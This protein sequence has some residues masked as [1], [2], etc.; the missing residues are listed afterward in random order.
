MKICCRCFQKDG[1][2]VKAV[3]EVIF[4]TIPERY[5]L[6][7]SCNEL[8]R[9]FINNPKI[10]KESFTYKCGLCPFEGKSEQGLKVHM[11]AKHS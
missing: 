5:D 3:G 6:C 2:P 11:K 8:V 9:G 4:N 1:K 7:Q 10:E